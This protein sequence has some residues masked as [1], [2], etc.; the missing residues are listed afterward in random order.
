MPDDSVPISPDA[1]ATLKDLS[2]R[3]GEP[4]PT[5]LARAIDMYR[6]QQFLVDAKRAYAALRADPKA[7]DE[8]LAERAE[9]DATLGDGV[10]DE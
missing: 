2:E 1:Y 10:D 7:W 5:I 8:E 4:I 3:N 9:W 6:R